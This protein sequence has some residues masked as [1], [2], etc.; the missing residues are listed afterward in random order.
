M[1]QSFN[2]LYYMNCQ[3]VNFEEIN[4]CFSGQASIGTFFW[5][6]RTIYFYNKGYQGIDE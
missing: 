1:L 6:G 4:A 5:G 2:K 3:F